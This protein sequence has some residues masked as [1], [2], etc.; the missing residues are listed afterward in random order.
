M[1]ASVHSHQ[2]TD[3]TTDP[4]CY[5][6]PILY[7]KTAVALPTL[8]CVQAPFPAPDCM[9]ATVA[10]TL[11]VL[12]KTDWNCL[13]DLDLAAP[14]L[15]PRVRY[16]GDSS[17]RF[18]KHQLLV[19]FD[20][21]QELLTLPPDTSFALHGPYIDGSLMRNHVA[22]WLY[23][24]TGRYSPRTQHVAV[25]I[26][27]GTHKPKYFGLYLLLETIGYGPNRVGLAENKATCAPD[28]QSGGWGWQ[29]NPL[30]YG[31]YSPN[32]MQDQYQ[33]QFGMGARPILMF[34]PGDTTSQAMRDAFVGEKG[35][36]PQYYRYL[37]HNMTSP[38]GLKQHIDL[39]S[40]A[41][42][43]L[44]T[45]W[46]LNQDAYTR[47]AYFFKDRHLPVE[48]GPVWDFNLAFGLGAR[49]TTAAW[50]FTQQPAWMRLLCNFEFAGLV[51]ARWKTLR[52]GAWSDASVDAFVDA[53]A[54][55]LLRTLAKCH[56]WMTDRESCASVSGV[57]HGSYQDQLGQLKASMAAR[58]AWMDT[59]VDALY[60]RL[61]GSFCG[62]LPEFN[63][64]LDG[65]D[66]GC[67][68][69]PAAYYAAVNATPAIRQPYA[70]P[71]CAP[72]SSVNPNDAYNVPSI[73]PCWLSVGSYVTAGYI[74]LTCSGHGL[75]PPG[76][77]A[78][79]QCANQ[80]VTADCSST[81][82]FASMLPRHATT[83]MVVATAVIV[84]G[85]ALFVRRRRPIARYGG[86]RVKLTYGTA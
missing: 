1:L 24:N 7:I 13:G 56:N 40:F 26:A 14:G 66:G 58:A 69:N 59:N 63:C 81:V 73:D 67:V 49:A 3:P 43:L 34:P 52:R 21:P 71:P 82:S 48:A 62:T 51:I 44:H 61:D 31:T 10:S 28:D 41:D 38:L 76:P 42:Y 29:F 5:S 53:A 16:R 17:L 79:C 75:C 35:F 18:V 83:V 45:E 25:Y 84:T 86:A 54:A 2:P 33:G 68:T 46:S 36:L 4:Q 32:I 22:H 72:S 30:M 65:H 6:V 11:H 8:E 60:R 39:G 19:K 74:T 77:N 70:G 55:P 27:E 85:L 47:S 23:R 50:M 15:T 37:W 80:A 12:N 64:A 57:N 20:T 9:K 78:T